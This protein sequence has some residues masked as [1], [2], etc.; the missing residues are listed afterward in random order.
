MIL[1]LLLAS[2]SLE[3]VGEP[4]LPPAQISAIKRY[5]ESPGMAAPATQVI[6]RLQL[7]LVKMRR[8]IAP[9]CTVIGS[10]FRCALR[11]SPRIASLR[12]NGHIPF[13]LLRSDLERRSS[14][15]PGRHL[16]VEAYGSDAAP[17]AALL[18]KVGRRL[19]RF[20]D[21]RGYAGTRSRWSLVRRCVGARLISKAY[22]VRTR[23]Y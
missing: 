15:R 5:L 7:D 10:S 8:F 18:A 11:Q 6:E 13:E 22:R 2:P 20:V 14:L 3:L 12:I 16:P 4:P 17:F 1:M 9:R 19:S 23:W 21:A